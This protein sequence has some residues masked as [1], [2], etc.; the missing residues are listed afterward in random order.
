[1]NEEYKRC[2]EDPIYFVEKY[3]SIEPIKL[4]DYQ[5]AFIKYLYKRT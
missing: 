3:C 5:K 2:L 1:M 4:K